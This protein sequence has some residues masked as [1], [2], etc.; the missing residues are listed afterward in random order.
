M[1]FKIKKNIGI[2]WSV[3]DGNDDDD[4]D[5]DNCNCEWK[6]REKEGYRH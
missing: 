5:N 2:K 3:W 4:D 6:S 1:I